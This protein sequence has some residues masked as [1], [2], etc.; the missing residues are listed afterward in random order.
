MLQRGYD[1]KYKNSFNMLRPEANYGEGETTENDLED[2]IQ[3]SIDDQNRFYSPWRKYVIIKYVEK[4]FN[5]QYLCL[6]LTKLWKIEENIIFIDLGEDFYIVKLTLEES[7]KS[8][9]HEGSQLYT[10]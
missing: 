8:L 3:L 7:Q 6:K 4:K 10:K 5:H 1:G 2:S 9:P